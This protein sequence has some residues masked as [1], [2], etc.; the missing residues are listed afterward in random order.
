LAAEWGTWWIA[1]EVELSQKQAERLSWIV[2]SYRREARSSEGKQLRGVLY[3]VD[4]ERR[5]EAC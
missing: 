5:A 2:S 1:V 4:D 3:L